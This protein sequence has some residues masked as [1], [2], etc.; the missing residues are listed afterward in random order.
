MVK[1]W[2]IN[3]ISGYPSL[4]VLL[5]FIYPFVYLVEINSHIY[6]KEQLL[7][8]SVFMLLFSLIAT[9]LITVTARYAVKIFLFILQ[10]FYPKLAMD[11]I[12]RKLNRACLGSAG[13]VI[14]LVLLHSANRELIPVIH[15]VLWVPLYLLAAIFVGI[16]TYFYKPRLLNIILFV[17]I[18][19]NGAFGVINGLKGDTEIG[20]IKID[21]N[22]VFKEKPNVYLVILESYASLEMREQIYGIDNKP[23]VNELSKRNYTAYKTYTNYP[24]S[25][26]SVSSIFMMQHHYFKPSRGIADGA[27]RNII[28]GEIKNPVIKIFLNNGYLI[29]YSGFHPYFYQPSANVHTQQVRPLLQPV[30][31]FDRLIA[32]LNVVMKRFYLDTAPFKTLLWMPERIFGMPIETVGDT[33]KENIGKP[34]FYVIYAGANHPPNSLLDYPDEIRKFPGANK[35]PS[36]KLNQINNYWIDTYK[37]LVMQSDKDLIDLIR[38]IDEKDPSAVVVLIGDHGPHFNGGRW[39]G[40]ENDL[41][42]N[43]FVNGIQPSEL[44][45]D[46]FEVFMAVK[47]P[48]GTEISPEY[49]SH[50]NLFRHVFAALTRDRAIL[51]TQVPNDC[52][53]MARKHFRFGK[54]QLYLTVQDGKVLDLWLPFTNLPEK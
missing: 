8:A 5:S 52:F 44:T 3:R 22:I 23:L 10:H 7:V 28:G 1:S 43:I 36:W 46:C 19:F 6:R 50:V 17:L 2:S 29:D 20:A 42:K 31:V 11:V 39:E 32:F 54:N 18:L 51:K 15:N 14:L 37:S 26:P 47:W 4:F 53:I 38:S 25:L 34:V 33:I 40:K 45:R 12:Y 24:S 21:Q 16:I 27:Y 13:T 9:F 48:R 35:M 41:N 30:E 49:F